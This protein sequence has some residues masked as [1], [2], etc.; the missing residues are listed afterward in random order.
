MTIE[1][2]LLGSLKNSSSVKIPNFLQQKL[3]NA[4]NQILLR[5][6]DTPFNGELSYL[7]FADGFC[8]ETEKLR[9]PSFYSCTVSC[10]QV[11]SDTMLYFYHSRQHYDIRI[12]FERITCTTIK[13]KRQETQR[14]FLWETIKDKTP[15]LPQK[16]NEHQ[17]QQ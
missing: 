2:L 13:H 1:I 3:K 4:R 5:Q 12:L 10:S 16:Q 17:W 11:S 8:R 6:K 15:Q 9:S 7:S 14:I